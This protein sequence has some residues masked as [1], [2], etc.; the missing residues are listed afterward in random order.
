MVDGI[1]KRVMFLIIV[2]YFSYMYVY[3]YMYV[4][5]GRGQRCQML[6]WI[7]VCCQLSDY[8]VRN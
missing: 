3:V 5:I 7:Y 6:S 2:F 1:R 8:G 4:G